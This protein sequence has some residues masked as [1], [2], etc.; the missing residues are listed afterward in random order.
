MGEVWFT[1]DTHFGHENI[2]KY[3]DRPFKDVIEMNQVMYDNWNAIVAPE[4]EIYHLGDLALFKKD[5]PLIELLS[6]L[7]GHKHLLLGNHDKYSR[8][9]FRKAG[10]IDIIH[11][12]IA[13]HKFLLS[14][15]PKPV[16][17]HNCR[18]NIHGHIHNGREVFMVG[19]K[20]IYYNV[21]VECHN[22]SPVNFVNIIKYYD[23]D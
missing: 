9:M 7:Q 5:S 4:D 2:I 1:S 21:S 20:N 16:T 14:H 18:A 8:T 17:S 11:T 12:P 19:G 22:Y 23:M 10:F 3:C 13:Y 6:G 15:A